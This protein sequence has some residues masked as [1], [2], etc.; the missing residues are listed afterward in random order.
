MRLLCLS[1]GHG[2]DQIAIRIL[3]ELRRLEPD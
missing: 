3:T 2:E 1:N